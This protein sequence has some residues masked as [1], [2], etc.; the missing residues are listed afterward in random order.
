VIAIV[1]K[2][3][4]L[5]LL[6]L[7]DPVLND[8]GQ[9]RC[10]ILLARE[11]CKKYDVSVVAPTISQRIDSKLAS[12]GVQTVDL[13]IRSHTRESSTSWLE[14]CLLEALF[15]R[16]SRKL[17]RALDLRTY[18]LIGF[19]CIYGIP[20][21]DIAYGQGLISQPLVSMDAI[22]SYYRVAIKMLNPLI[23]KID[24]EFIVEAS[25]S[26]RIVI[27][28]SEYC[29]SVYRRLGIRVHD[30]ITPPLECE[31]FK[32]TVSDI[33][34]DYILSYVGKETD[35]TVIQKLARIGIRMKMFGTK[36]SHVPAD[37]ARNSNVELLG[38]VTN[39]ELVELYSN[40]YYTLFPFTN[41]YF[42]YVPVESMACGTPVLTYGLEGPGETVID[43]MTGWLARDREEIVQ[44]ATGLMR[45]GYPR[46]MRDECRKHGLRFDIKKVAE[47]WM[48]HI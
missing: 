34:D 14:T 41:E 27:A 4:F 22:P 32:P 19:T 13:N 18:K 43:G 48:R 25:K 47:R 28:N 23:S 44:I 45:S 42:G 6:L 37:L 29:A 30:V 1:Y 31:V 3:L 11:L 10:V 12:W 21:Y 46:N 24:Q 20:A 16:N 2:V 33:K 26:S 7:S 17:K 15:S 40:A 38:H 5:K 39:K 9:T 35:F 8:Y 36:S